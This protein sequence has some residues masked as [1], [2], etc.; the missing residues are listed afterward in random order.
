MA[1]AGV[2]VGVR[3]RGELAILEPRGELSV[4]GTATLERAYA[5]AAAGRPAAILIDF[6]G[7]PYINSTGIAVIVGLLARARRD[8][9]PMLACGLS[10]HYRELFR[11]TRIADVLELVANEAEAV[12][13]A[14]GT[15]HPG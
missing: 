2:E 13:A 6:A 11:I 1:T 10:D 8:D 14:S 15:G 9:R 4:A 7:V 5:E 3:R 12:A